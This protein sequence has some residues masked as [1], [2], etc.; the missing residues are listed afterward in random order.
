MTDAGTIGRFLATGLLNTAFGYGLYALLVA[1]GLPYLPALALATVAGVVFNYFSFGRL[2]F[3]VALARA[4][5]ARFVAGYGLA[6]AL[7][8]ALLWAAHEQLGLD[9]YTAQLACLPPTVVETY[10]ILDRWVYAD[11]RPH[12]R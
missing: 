4:T 3:R 2:A 11:A 7:N 9:P 6:L 8:A 12:G 1:A 10:L 5:F